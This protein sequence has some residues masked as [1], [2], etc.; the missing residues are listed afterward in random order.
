MDR[1]ALGFPPYVFRDFPPSIGNLTGLLGALT[2]TE[3]EMISVERL[4]DYRDRVDGDTEQ[5]KNDGTYQSDRSN[6][7]ARDPTLADTQSSDL[8]DPTTAVSLWNND[9][10]KN[11][12][13]ADQVSS[14]DFTERLDGS[15]A[16]R[17]R[18]GGIREGD[19]GTSSW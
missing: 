6:R 8:E 18:M 17:R 14:A 2:E 1:I 4:D 19:P 5:L 3:R 12:V 13:V 7:V 9:R 16:R 15:A 10:D 11:D